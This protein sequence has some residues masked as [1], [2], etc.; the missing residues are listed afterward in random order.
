MCHLCNYKELLIETGLE[1]T[2]NRIRVLEVIGNNG[3]PLTAG[4]VYQTLLRSGP[5]NKVTVYRI[6]DLFAEKNL[7]VC[8]NSFGRLTYYGMGPNHHHIPHAHFLCKQCG[9][10]DCLDP[11]SLQVDSTSLW[12]SFPGQIEGVEVRVDG[13]CKEC[14]K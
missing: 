8:L 6:L 10:I 1:A 14:M 4:E 12:K 11:N 9:R 5:I 13:I 3:F 7:V 2:K